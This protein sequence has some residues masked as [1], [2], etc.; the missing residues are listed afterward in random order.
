MSLDVTKVQA[1]KLVYNGNAQRA[2]VID[3]DYNVDGVQLYEYN[4]NQTFTQAGVYF[5]TLTVRAFR[6]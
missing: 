1:G 4:R 6:L 2:I 5:L 3:N